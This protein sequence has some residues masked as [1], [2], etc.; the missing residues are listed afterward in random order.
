MTLPATPPRDAHGVEALAVLQPVDDR[1][2]RHVV[3]KPVEDLPRRVDG[4]GPQPGAGAVRA[5]PGD[6][7]LDA[8]RALAPRLDA[9]IGR[10]HEDGEVGLEQLGMVVGERLQPVEAGVHLLALV[11]D[12]R[13]V[14]HG[15]GHRGG[16]R[17]APPPRRPSCRRRRGRRAG[18]PSTRC[19]RLPCAGTVS[20][21]PPMSTRS[22]RPSWVRATTVLPCRVTVR[23]ET[24]RRAAS[25]ASASGA[26]VARLA[27]NV[28][29]HGGQGHGPRGEVQ[30][31]DR[32]HVDTVAV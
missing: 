3:A 9:G 27:G 23:C 19:G 31:W 28:H 4:V 6:G 15:V 12:V 20:R 16:Q 13:D 2:P 30:G 26:L 21:C 5:G 32:G 18:P 22:A 29:E 10:L 11:E 8:Q 17:R 1:L 14:T 7:D 25:T 24:G